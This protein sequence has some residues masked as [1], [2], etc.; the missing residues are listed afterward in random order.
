MK[1][2][3]VFRGADEQIVISQQSNWGT[4]SNIAADIDRSN[5]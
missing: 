3:S 5:W 1:Q 4:R 2:E